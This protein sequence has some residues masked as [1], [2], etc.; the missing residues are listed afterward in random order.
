MSTVTTT[1]SADYLISPQSKALVLFVPN[2]SGVDNIIVDS[3]SNQDFYQFCEEYFFGVGTLNSAIH[4]FAYAGLMLEVLEEQEFD[5]NEF[6]SDGEYTIW[7]TPQEWL[8][9]VVSVFDE[10]TIV[11]CSVY[12]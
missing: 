3:N 2:Q 9:K 11:V 5:T 7:S 6:A 1:K 8:S 10:D 12:E 4:P